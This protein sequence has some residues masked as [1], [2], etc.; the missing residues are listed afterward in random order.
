MSDVG[1]SGINFNRLHSDLESLT[2]LLIGTQAKLVNA[3][4]N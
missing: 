4:K 3:I 1:G 2:R